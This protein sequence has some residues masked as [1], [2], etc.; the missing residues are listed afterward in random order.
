MV[1]YFKKSTHLAPHLVL[2]LLFL[3]ASTPTDLRRL[4][5]SNAGSKVSYFFNFNFKK[6][7]RFT[8]T[9]SFADGRGDAAGAAGGAAETSKVADVPRH[10]TAAE[11]AG[12]GGREPRSGRGSGSGSAEGDLTFFGFGRIFGFG[13]FYFLAL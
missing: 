1:R 10:A 9:F 7:H 4:P 5:G 12:R 11:W 6:L 3:L 8:L 13:F 2:L